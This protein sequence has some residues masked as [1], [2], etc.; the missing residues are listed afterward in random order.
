MVFQ[1]KALLFLPFSRGLRLG[2]WRFILIGNKTIS[3]RTVSGD[4]HVADL[5]DV[6]D[7][8]DDIGVDDE[9]DG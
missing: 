7:E 5:V 3:F 6:D 1:I 9:D 4:I 2:P 8:D